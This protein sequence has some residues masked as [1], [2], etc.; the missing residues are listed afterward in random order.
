MDKKYNVD[1]H[2]NLISVS[3]AVI[4]SVLILF[5]LGNYTYV[6]RKSVIKNA[7]QITNQTAEYI[8]STIANEMGY[9]KSSIRLSAVTIAQQMTSDTL[10]NPSDVISP[11]VKNTPFGGV[12][13][14]RADGMN[15]MNIGEPFDASDRVYYIEGMKGNTGVWN[16]FH[17]KTSK[18]TL[19]NFYT[20]LVYEGKIAGVITGYIEATAQIAPL[21][22][23][24]LYGQ[25]VYGLLVD[26][27][28]MVICSTV[29]SEYV[30]DLTLD[31]FMDGLGSSEE[32]KQ[33]MVEVLSKARKKAA[34]FKEE[35]GN[36]RICVTQI[37]ETQWKVVII[38]PE[39]SFEG[40]VSENTK[41]SINAIV[42]ISV[43]I[44]LYASYMLLKNAKRRKKIAAEKAKLQVENM[45]IRD[46]IAS[47]DMGT[48]RIE[49]FDGEEPRMYVDSTMKRLLGIDNEKNTPE[50][51]YSSWFA[52]I[53]PEAVPSVLDSVER[54]QNGYF[55]ENTYLWTHPTKGV[56]YVRC[57]GTAQKTDKGSVLRGYHYDVDDVVREDQAKVAMLSDALNEKNE[58]YSTLGTL[59]G[60]FYSMHV[61]DLIEDTAI[62]FNSRDEV[63]EIVNHQQGAIEMMTQVMST[64]TVDEYKDEALEFTDLTTLADR[65]KDKT[66]I[67][68]EFIGKHVG[69]F[70]ASFITMD[71]DEDGKPTKVIC[72]TRVI[73]DEKKQEEKLIRRAQ[74]DELTGLF[75][76]R[77]Y[78]DDIYE[79]NDTPQEDDFVY[80][81]LDVNGLKV[82]NDTQGHMAGDELIIGACQCM[83][84]S[85]GSYGR[86]Y[87][88]GGDEFVAIIFCNEEKLK[89][90]LADLDDTI[91]S[92][93]GKLID[94][95]S[96]SYG[97][98]SKKEEPTLSV[99]QLGAI[100]EQ[101]MYDAKAEHYK[102]TGVDRRG[103][104]DAH[105]ALCDLYTKILRINI[106]DDTYQI[107]D[108]DVSEQIAEKG[109]ADSISKWFT[110]FGESGQ[111]HQDDLDEYLKF[112]DLKYMRDYFASDKTS[113]HV[114]YRRKYED[115]FKQ[116][117]ME[118]IPASDYSNDNQ[119]LF[120]Y[121][122]NI[123]K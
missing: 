24:E 27:N 107:I 60:I 106:T 22:E 38:V 52:N 13:Y 76:R 108:M 116:V 101:R 30:K 85:L 4:V 51:V 91:T 94:T 48:W 109:F 105:K 32:E 6:Q 31:M 49:L 114:F 35:K 19:M 96:I 16:N 53:T 46:I 90:I 25:A 44:M 34:S 57:G 123:D 68:K 98:I 118:V 103:Q 10:E 117:M 1:E 23:K 89:E 120:L 43:I 119:S 111:V 59:E 8:A 95:L 74:T 88:I 63:R 15:V 50:Q 64:V 56:R 78:E 20:P 11:M 65:M 77:T 18:E 97:W 115:G 41:N 102:Q 17:P 86:L 47:A 2:V 39:E 21:F 83:K 121:V 29:E 14:I 61:L 104:K 55:D 28:N 36:G 87:R 84:K 40:L 80:V 58:Y 73:D 79:H 54:M 93:K 100:A 82:V 92:W 42:A 12:E 99:R 7:E 71:V 122:K 70:L 33:Y 113:L 3:L 5:V 67:S 72:T 110:S 62:E 37:P 9:A 112:T 69:W 45:E 66:I 26:E 75:N 81:S